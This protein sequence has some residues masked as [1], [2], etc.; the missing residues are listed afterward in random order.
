MAFDLATATP[1]AGFDLSTAKPAKKVQNYTLPDGSMHTSTGGPL[2]ASAIPNGQQ[3]PTSGMSTANKFWA[4]AGKAPVDLGRGIGQLTG[5]ESRADVAESRARDAALMNTTAGKVGNLT[6]NVAQLVPTAFIPGANTLAGAGTIGALAGLLQPSTSTGETAANVGLGGVLGPTGLLA[7]RG[8]AGAYGLGRGLLEPFLP[9]GPQR[10]AARALQGFAGSPQDAA[11]AAFNLTRPQ[12]F[13]TGLEPTT[14]E[15][16]QNPGLSQLQ[17]TL[18]NNPQFLTDLT[19]R[20]QANRGVMTGALR[21]IAG[22]EGDMDVALAARAK[23]TK[24]LYETAAQVQVPAD[25][26]LAALLQRPSMKEAVANAQRI[27]EES[28]HDFM[29][30]GKLSGSDVQAIKQSLADA[31]NTGP[32]RGIGANQLHQVRGT[33]N[34][35]NDWVA[36]NVPELKVADAEFAAKSAPINQM[37][38]GTELSNKL[39]PALND[40]GNAGGLNANN[41]AAAVRNGDQ[42]AASTTGFKGATL[43]NTLSPQHMQTIQQV[44]EQ[45]ARTA[46]TNVGRATGSNTAQNLIGEDFMRRIL[47]PLGLPKTLAS[48]VIAKTL[49]RPVDF[50]AKMAEPDI[51]GLLQQAALDPKVAAGLLQQVTNN[52]TLAR[53][54]WARQGLLSAPMLGLANSPQQ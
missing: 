36:A 27:A 53:A 48:S 26:K 4:G 21:N 24:P 52:P 47:G 23:D 49:S 19:N 42:L 6:G 3:D 43:A 8:V 45:L 50:M 12:K 39:I 10:I 7:G 16:A 20:T 11:D 22:T 35:F 32:Q 51:T 29:P 46:G 44:G 18:Q 40:F 37:A 54:L 2:P 15:L 9:Q 14:A 25:A 34:A 38:V 30:G 31:I 17:R 41:F 33:S 28:G 1:V 13:L 5:L